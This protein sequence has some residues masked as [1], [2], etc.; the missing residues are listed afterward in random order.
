MDG[1]EMLL[2][3]RHEVYSDMA[4]I[5]MTARDKLPDKLAGCR[6]GADD[7]ITKAFHLP[8]LEMRLQALQMRLHGRARNRVLE[9]EDL[10]LDLSTLEASR[11][12]K[13]VR[14]FPAG[15]ELLEVLMRARPP[16]G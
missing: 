16:V 1:P 3:L 10:R 8:E 12:G 4:V 7:Y 6:A 5:M 15:R 9:V 11:G 2:K 14:L 13:L